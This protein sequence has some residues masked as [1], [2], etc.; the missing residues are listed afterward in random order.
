M[1]ILETK[2]A[3]AGIGSRK[4]PKNILIVMTKLGQAFAKLEGEGEGLCRVCVS[5]LI[6]MALSWWNPDQKYRVRN[7]ERERVEWSLGTE[8]EFRGQCHL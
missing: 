3:Y 5:E 2:P 1:E 6:E 7:L 4:T 8:I